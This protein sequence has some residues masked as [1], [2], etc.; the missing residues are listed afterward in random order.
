MPFYCSE[1]QLMATAAVPPQHSFAAGK[2]CYIRQVALI[3]IMA[4]T[5][6]YVPADSARLHVFDSIHTRMGASDNLALGKL[7]MPIPY[8][9]I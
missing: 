7:F 1:L 6:C 4:Q 8:Q 5:G 3:A 9:Q 2:S